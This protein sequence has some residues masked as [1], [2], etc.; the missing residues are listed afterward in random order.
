MNVVDRSGRP[1]L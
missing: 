1:P